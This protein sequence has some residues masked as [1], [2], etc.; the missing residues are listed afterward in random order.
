MIKMLSY[1]IR[2]CQGVIRCL[3]YVKM[4]S[5]FHEKLQGLIKS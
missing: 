3:K 1:V 5:V 4:L 2:I